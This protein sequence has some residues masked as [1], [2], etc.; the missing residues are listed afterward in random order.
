MHLQAGSVLSLAALQPMGTECAMRS[1]SRD[2][3]GDLAVFLWL[4]IA[5]GAVVWIL[6]M[7]W[8]IV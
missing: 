1:S 6:V 2:H 3:L 8:D 4:V 5:F 7:I